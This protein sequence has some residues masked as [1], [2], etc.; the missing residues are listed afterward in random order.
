MVAVARRREQAVIVIITTITAPTSVA[1]AIEMINV[2]VDQLPAH[3]VPTGK[4]NATT[5]GA[6]LAMWELVLGLEME[7]P[8]SE[9]GSS[10]Q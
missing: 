1:A 9:T 2:V 8:A 5:T 6:C 10:L 7:A 4:L 3:R